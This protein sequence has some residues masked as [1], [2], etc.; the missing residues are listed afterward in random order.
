MPPSPKK[1]ADLKRRMERIG[2]RENNISEH[3]VR[4]SG[5]GGQNVN[6]VSTCVV[7][8]HEPTGLEVKC[9]KTRQ[10]VLNRY[11]ARVTLCEKLEKIILGKQSEAEKK[12]WKLRKQKKR[13]SKKAKEKV[14]EQKKKLSEKKRL[15]SAVR[16]DS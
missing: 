16:D 2:V 4:S 5:A 11:Y 9:Q 3:F 14:L 13:R 1:E 12:R 7:L 8:K 15:R 6:K 10:Q